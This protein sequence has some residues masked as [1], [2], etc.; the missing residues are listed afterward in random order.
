MGS[1][2]TIPTLREWFF[3]TFSEEKRSQFA[4]YV[5]LLK[6]VNRKINLVSRKSIDSVEEQHLYPSL[7]LL[8]FVGLQGV[9]RCLDVGSGGGFPGI[10]LAIALPSIHFTLVEAK[11]KKTT[12][13]QYFCRELKLENVEVIWGRV[14]ELPVQQKYDLVLGRAVTDLVTFYRWTHRLLRPRVFP[15]PTLP[16]S[17][18]LYYKGMDQEELKRFSPPPR[19]FLLS[20][21]FSDPHLE[22]KTI[23]YLS[24]QTRLIC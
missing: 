8:S 24:Y 1:N 20:D 12:C 9:E 3:S 13:L 5:T 17:G 15:D 2:S 19:Y 7:A 23:V 22:M 16:E 11:K 4:L 18:I 14:E 21:F 6:E 10:P